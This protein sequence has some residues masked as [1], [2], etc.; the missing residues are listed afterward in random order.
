MRC[1]VGTIGTS[2]NA[3]S[4][5]DLFVSRSKLPS[6][7]CLDTLNISGDYRNLISLEYFCSQ[8]FHSDL[9]PTFIKVFILEIH[10]LKYIDIK[11]YLLCHNII[12]L[13]KLN[14]HTY[15]VNIDNCYLYVFYKCIINFIYIPIIYISF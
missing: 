10:K 7:Q 6:Y 2:P 11:L 15:L 3:W 12:I 1:D 13:F 14:L 4:I 9:F 5:F 8:I